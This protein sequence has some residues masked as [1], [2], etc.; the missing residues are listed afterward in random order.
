MRRSRLAAVAVAVAAAGCGGSA[1]TPD[2]ALLTDVRAEGARVE[3]VFESPPR[4]VSARYVDE[5]REDGSGRLVRVAGAATLVVR[6]EPAATADL[7]GEKLR[8][9]YDG[10]RRLRASGPVLEVVKVGDFESQ[11]AWAIGLDR[12]RP[13]EL[14]REGDRVV[15]RV[16]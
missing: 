7:A 14:E 6:F 10:P 5:V 8:V 13:H 3:F 15:V 16:G 2:V 1:S 4:E 11:L 12:R 9:T